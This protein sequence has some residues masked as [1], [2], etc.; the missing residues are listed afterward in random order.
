MTKI[1]VEPS[2]GQRYRVEVEEAGG[3]TTHQVTVPPDALVR[4]GGD[5]PESLIRESFRFLL[6]R[7]P[8]ESIL[9]S[10]ELDVI[11]R[12]FPEYPREIKRRLGR[13]PQGASGA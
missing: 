10:F 1:H 9:R 12:Y 13:G 8:K 2:G 11:A 5:S 3:T 7:E 6:E 4:Y